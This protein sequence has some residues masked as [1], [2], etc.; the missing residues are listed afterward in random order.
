MHNKIH[1]MKRIALLNFLLA[2]VF[3]S[4]C[5]SY[6]DKE[7]GPVAYTI[8]MEDGDEDL[9]EGPIEGITTIKFTPEDFGFSKNSVGG[10]RLKEITLKTDNSAGFGAF[11]NLKIEVSSSNTDMLTIGVLNAV[12]AGNEITITGLD[13]AKIKKFKE[14]DEF[15]LHI[16]GNLLEDM[17]EA[18]SIS[19][20]FILRVESSEK[21][22]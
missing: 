14:V 8:Q 4:S 2:G 11:D 19:G 15:Y 12:P 5:T 9:F 20:E 18:F 1:T 21:D 3:V 7:Y 16:S 6:E 22:D 17:E 10:M 13:E